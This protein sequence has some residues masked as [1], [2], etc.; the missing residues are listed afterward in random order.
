MGGSESGGSVDDVDDADDSNALLLLPLPL[1][2]PEVPSILAR[3]EALPP[4]CGG[5]GPDEEP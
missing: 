4:P 1:P 5:E 2:L 3:R